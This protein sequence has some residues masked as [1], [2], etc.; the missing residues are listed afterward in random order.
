M[1]MKWKQIVGLFLTL[2]IAWNLVSAAIVP[3]VAT[4]STDVYQGKVFSILGDSIST[5]SGYI[6]EEDGFN[7]AH[8]T[9]YPDTS[10]VPDV[11]SVNQTWWMQLINTLG[12]K[13]GINDSWRGTTV[14]NSVTAEVDGN[15][16]TKATLSS[17]TRIQNLGANGTPDVIM[18]FGGTNDIRLGRELGDFD[19]A[20]APV[21]G[22]YNDWTTATWSSVADAYAA[23]LVR[24]KELYPNA[25]IISLLPTYCTSVTAYA[26]RLPEYNALFAEI[27]NHYDVLY[28]DLRYCGIEATEDY[29][30]DGLHPSAA[31]M[32]CI[33][34]AVLSLLQ[35][36]SADLTAGEH[37]VYKITHELSNATASKFYYKGVDAGESFTETITGD[38]SAITVIMDGVDVT[39]TVYSD[40]VINIPEVTGYV[41]ITDTL[42]IDSNG[43]VA[44]SKTASLEGNGTYS[45]D[46]SG[47]VTGVTTINEYE[48][49]APL[50]VVLVLD[51]STSMLQFSNSAETYPARAVDTWPTTE[52]YPAGTT[53]TTN[54]ASLFTANVT[55]KGN[56][57]FFTENSDGTIEVKANASIKNS[58]VIPVKEGDKIYC[59]SFQAATVTGGNAN[60][61]RVTYFKKNGTVLQSLAPSAVYNEFTG[62]N[63]EYITVPAD[64]YSMNV[65]L[66]KND[67]EAVIQNLSLDELRYNPTTRWE[68][69]NVRAKILQ[70]QIQS[71]AD[72]LAEASRVS[73]VEHKMAVV[74][75]GGAATG[76]AGPT[77]QGMYAK[78]VGV[79]GWW[80]HY[81]TNT[82]VFVD[83]QFK[84][85]YYQPSSENA[86]V[87]IDDANH[88]AYSPVY[89]VDTSKK[90]CHM[91]WDVNGDSG[92]SYEYDSD[93][94]MVWVEYDSASGTWIDETG[95]TVVP[96][97]SPY[98][99]NGSTLF[100][101]RSTYYANE[102]NRLKPTSSDYKN[103]L[104][105]VLGSDNQL[106]DNLQ[107]AL[108]RYVARGTTYTR[109]GLVMA[110][111]ILEQ[112]PVR[113][114]TDQH[115]VEYQGKQLV[116]LFT[117][118]NTNNS[119]SYNFQAANAIKKLGAELYTIGLDE[120]AGLKWMDQI[121]SNNTDFTQAD[122]NEDA[123]LTGGDYFLSIENASQLQNAFATITGNVNISSTTITL[124]DSAV[125][126]DYLNTGFVMPE[127]FGFG[128]ISVSTVALTTSDGAT[129]VEGEED[130][131]TYSQTDSEGYGIYTNT[132]GDT[133]KVSFDRSTGKIA[134]T[135]FDYAE[136]FVAADHAGKKLV[137][138]ITGVEVT[139]ETSIDQLI[140]TNGS[141]SG[142]LYTKEDNTTGVYAFALP[143][144]QL[145]SKIYIVDYAKPVVLAPTDWSG[146]YLG[147]A[148]EAR[149]NCDVAGDEVVTDAGTF[150]YNE[151][152]DTVTFTPTNMR[153]SEGA[154]FYALGTW[155]SSKPSGVTT[156]DNLWTKISIVPANSIYYEDDF[157]DIVYSGNWETV[158]TVENSTE[159]PEGATGDP[160][161]V[162]GWEE[163]LKD[164]QYSDGSAH[165]GVVGG[166]NMAEVTFT[167]VGKG[168]D[169]YCRTQS[170]TG[171]VLASLRGGDYIE[172]PVY[173]GYYEI[174]KTQ[175]VDT[176][177]VSGDYYQIPTISFMNLPY[178]TYT[179]T[180]RVTTGA[181]DRFVYYLDGLRVYNPLADDSAYDEKEQNAS[182]S[183][184]RDLLAD[185]E[186]ENRG[187]VF[188]DKTEDEVIG[189][190]KNYDETEYGLYGP[191]NEIYLTTG[192]SVTFKVGTLG[193][194]YYAGLKS[195]NGNGDAKA[196]VSN[197]DETTR[198]IEI[199]HS[200]DMYY[201]VVPDAE[202]YI[203]I[204][205]TGT[206]LLSIT[207]L[208]VAGSSEESQV[209]MISEKEA[210]RAVRSFSL[211]TVLADAQIPGG[212]D[213]PPTSDVNIG[214]LILIMVTGVVMLL[215]FVGGAYEKK[216]Y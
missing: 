187:A 113:V 118:G 142:I 170:T 138:N 204:E 146:S 185:T 176:Q 114:H 111:N 10:K 43:N 159:H 151:A 148:S 14:Y 202:G 206:G 61:I 205:N 207:K 147:M 124:D 35:E 116:I 32:D 6:P 156:G 161:G 121:S 9:R 15:A 1:R 120:A 8:K 96:R 36:N 109:F 71:F 214:I 174:S 101:S 26:D 27:C 173:G 165:K 126:Q 179:V 11:T 177:S 18:F 184:I 122:V 53:S 33:T 168:V 108:D 75:F 149:L 93:G 199:A 130:P 131:Y 49:A 73:G 92:N 54:L 56:G 196:K 119:T 78:H 123:E 21:V 50:D 67:G 39:S 102:D 66:W 190:A 65:T 175:I 189:A 178:G 19:S 55:E 115:G 191:K 51:A 192:Q 213:N 86:Q 104:T 47:F 83:G 44:L 181:S 182:F 25:Q 128:N 31:G 20:T 186:S 29:L 139:S 89:D 90:Y 163:G 216:V 80:N 95:K 3:A 72:S 143:K 152:D 97:T 197:G 88:Y 172:D 40:G 132:S 158:G 141:D 145:N 103:A 42:T 12:G 22:S 140:D 82:G 69:A 70:E 30:P 100:Y 60:G 28:V 37:G 134:V 194:Y 105:S 212:T 153:W 45:I 41:Y 79:N 167:F 13:L 154:T 17:P 59:S 74:T 84:Q 81:F 137:V 4:G 193:A 195:P 144:T 77:Y 87:V 211:R 107:F 166:T 85:Y 46:L 34:N 136:N 24:M 64:A 57:R 169:I 125:M 210:V 162:H 99:S 203:T 183:E 160:D 5:F 2:T 58:I 188:V 76:G 112:N 133:L 180:I 68:F 164:L 7:A 200:S 48:S 127:S 38:T 117:D 23:T 52:T 209:L 215:F 208:R 110:G 91:E 63:G 62:N 150:T 135:G 157:D 201:V 155:D 94:D 171:T 129:Y 198:E 16:G 98:D 106:N